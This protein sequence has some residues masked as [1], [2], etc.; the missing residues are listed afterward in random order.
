MTSEN[1]GLATGPKPRKSTDPPTDSPWLRP[2]DMKQEVV[3]KQEHDAEPWTK[4][5]VED[6]VLE[7]AKEA[8]SDAAPEGSHNTPVPIKPQLNEWEI[9]NKRKS[10][11]NGLRKVDDKNNRTCGKCLKRLPIDKFRRHERSEVCEDCED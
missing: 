9:R 1:K 5:R 6:E 8:K 10:I 11:L 7:A 2:M 3:F 4:E